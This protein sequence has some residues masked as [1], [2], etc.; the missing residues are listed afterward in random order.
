MA[1]NR[2]QLNERLQ[3]YSLSARFD[4]NETGPDHAKQ[5]KCSCFV[6]SI[7]LGRSD[8]HSRKDAAKEEAAERALAWCDQYGYPAMPRV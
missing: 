5:W 4:W 8:W 2:E 1:N 3:W 6:G 7:L